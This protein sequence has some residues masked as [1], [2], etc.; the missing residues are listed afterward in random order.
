MVNF[1]KEGIFV[2]QKILRI[3]WIDEL[4]GLA[5]LAMILHHIC[6]NLI[7]FLE[8]SVPWLE[9][10]MESILFK[11]IQTAFVA[12]F[13]CLSG[14]CCHLTRHPLK[15]AAR[16]FSGA[17]LVTAVTYFM[18]PDEAIWFGILHCLAFCMALYALLKPYADRIPPRIGLP[19]FI[20]IFILTFG[21]PNGQ[22]LGLALPEALY[23]GGILMPLGFLSPDFQS[24][25][26][27]PLLPHL[28]LFCIGVTLGNRVLPVGKA[29]SRF[30]AFCGRHSL[31]I[32]LVHQPAV[33]GIF[34]ILSK[35]L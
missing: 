23:Q 6:F 27:V 16:V 18:Y 13:L 5:I 29:H 1:I 28:F 14:I 19:V 7:Y 35:I 12:V 15:R 10:F 24:L 22:I 17:L 31:F 2:S 30:L 9:A 21:I 8:L 25:D 11:G 34:F 20:A 4:R 26:Y 3:P 33:F 32:Y